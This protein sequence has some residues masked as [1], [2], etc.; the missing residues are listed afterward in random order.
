MLQCSFKLPNTLTPAGKPSR[1]PTHTH[2]RCPQCKR[3]ACS[4]HREKVTGDE[5]CSACCRKSRAAIAQRNQSSSR[6]QPTATSGFP[7]PP[8]PPLPPQQYWQV[9]I[10]V[11]TAPVQAARRPSWVDEG[12]PRT[13]TA[14]LSARRPNLIQRIHYR[15][16]GWLASGEGYCPACGAGPGP[17]FRRWHFILPVYLCKQC[18]HHPP[19]VANARK[20]ASKRRKQRSKRLL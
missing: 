10:P 11:P 1:C 15:R 9:P 8:P 13:T 14:H 12:S 16:M 3:V 19:R 6:R 2:F 18:F 7:P 4:A 5:L 20:R 17:L